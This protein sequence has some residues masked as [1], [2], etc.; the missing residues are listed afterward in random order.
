MAL[1][2]G[3]QPPCRR[4]G[5]TRRPGRAAAPA[6]PVQR[7]GGGSCWLDDEH[8]GRPPRRRQRLRSKPAFHSGFPSRRT[9]RLAGLT[10]PQPPAPSGPVSQHPFTRDSRTEIAMPAK[11]TSQAIEALEEHM[12]S[13]HDID[14]PAQLANT[15]ALLS[16]AENLDALVEIGIDAIGGVKQVIRVLDAGR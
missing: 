5:A 7:P 14:R 8:P 9:A 11:R 6:L 16:I 3:D 4:H 10:P 13:G 15:L 1:L 12:R 2:L